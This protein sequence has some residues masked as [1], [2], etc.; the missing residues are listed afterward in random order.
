MS[1]PYSKRGMTTMS[2]HPMKQNDNTM[3]LVTSSLLMLWRHA[4]GSLYQMISLTT[5]LLILS[6]INTSTMK[7]TH[8]ANI[9][10]GSDP[11]QSYDANWS[12]GVCYAPITG[13]RIGDTLEFRFGG[14]NVYRIPSLTAFEECDFSQAELLADSSASSYTHEITR[15]AVESTL[16]GSGSLFFA[17]GIGGHCFYQKVRVDVDAT[18]DR[19]TTGRPRRLRI[20]P[21]RFP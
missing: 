1:Y 7:M 20:L 9:V 18:E 21:R 17:C 13:A 5:T 2:Y 14:H 10:V 16:D 6:S 12:D 15:E 11:E 19:P 4:W 8:A 3:A